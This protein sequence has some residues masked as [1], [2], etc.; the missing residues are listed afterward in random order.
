MVETKTFNMK[1]LPLQFNRLDTTTNNDLMV[2]LLD[3]V[4]HEDS[5]LSSRLRPDDSSTSSTMGTPDRN[6][7]HSNNEDD[8]NNGDDDDNYV[9]TMMERELVDG[10]NQNNSNNNNQRQQ[11]IQS[12]VAQL[13]MLRMMRR[14]TTATTVTMIMRM[15]VSVMNMIRN[16]CVII[17]TNKCM[18][19][20]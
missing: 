4:D 14:T 2:G 12:L 17:T 13:E 16:T 3:P 5:R 10:S 11:H 9:G 19:L 18:G 8:N 1:R 15:I 7:N 6:N 20:V